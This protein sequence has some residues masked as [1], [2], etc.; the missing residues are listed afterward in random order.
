MAKQITKI[1]LFGG[2][3]H[4]TCCTLE[5]LLSKQLTPAYV[6]L[7]AYG[8]SVDDQPK[9]IANLSVPSP[10]EIV[11]L[12]RHHQIPVYYHS[13]KSSQVFSQ[14]KNYQ[15]D[16]ILL[17]CY[18]VKLPMHVTD[19][20]K[21]DCINI[22]PS[23]LPK[24]RGSNPLFWQLRMGET[25]TGVTLH[26]VTS[27]L[28]SGEIIQQIEVP[29]ANGARLE[30]IEQFLIQTVVDAFD[31]LLQIPHSKWVT[32]AQD[33]AQATEHCSPSREDYAFSTND[34]A[35]LVYNF[36]R[37]YGNK[38]IP[39]MIRSGVEQYSGLDPIS[40]SSTPF[41]DTGQ[42]NSKYVTIAFADGFVRF[43][44]IQTR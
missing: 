40:W 9:S 43:Q 7:H 35:L 17:A 3:S 25:K 34:S 19:L 28:D 32:Q 14:L 18:P 10:P 8:S 15:I 39:S 12:C 41:E 6:V 44:A 30:E 23:L 16:Y 29:F 20:A 5:A 24:Y 42:D 38:D 1:G 33:S 11:R 22:H 2:I 13:S 36:I 4:F 31:K 37:A 27:E 21:I 26:R